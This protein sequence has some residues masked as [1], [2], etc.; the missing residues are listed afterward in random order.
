MG[1]PVVP[2]AGTGSFHIVIIGGNARS[3]IAN[4]GDLIQDLLALGHRVTGL[5]PRADALPYLNDL[6]IPVELIDLARGRMNPWADLRTYRELK[7]RIRRLAPD[8]IFLYTIKPVIIGSYAA[9]SAGVRRITSMI[10]GLGYLFAGNSWRQRLGRLVAGTL[11][12]GSLGMNDVI[13]FQNPDDREDFSKRGLLRP[14]QTIVVTNG[15]GVH[16]EKFQPAPVPAGPPRFLLAARLLRDKGIREFVEAAK[17]LQKDCPEAQW[18]VLGPYPAGLP[19]AIPITELE[20]LRRAGPVVFRDAVK[21]V[22]PHLADCTVFVLPS[23]YREGTPRAILEA[24]AMGRAVITTD[25][26][27]CRETV[28]DGV[29]GC[30]VRPRDVPSLVLAM[31]RF[32]D[33]P[34]MAFRMGIESRKYAE[35]KFDVR[36]VNRLIISH[37]LIPEALPRPVAV[38]G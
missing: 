15:S 33:D 34:A 27:G 9:K 20:Q 19:G 6:T 23:Y 5:V 31:R 4:R 29:N 14:S 11:Y 22:R 35:S 32:I 13:F 17:I 38:T 10:P 36:Q 12:R 7:R 16:L 26:P 3:L 18:I 37:L 25:A 1:M 21:D 24:M 8:I 28:I 2:S 30:L